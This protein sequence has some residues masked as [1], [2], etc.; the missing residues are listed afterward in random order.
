MIVVKNDSLPDYNERVIQSPVLRFLA[1]LL[2]Y[3]FHPA[4]VPV[5]MILFMVYQHPYFF[6][7]MMPQDKFRVTA[8]SVLMFSFFPIVTVGLLKALGFI[9]SIYLHTQ[10]DRIIPLVACGVFY[11][12]ITY[13]W[14]NSNKINGNFFIP[15]EAVQFA[16]ATFF[17]SWLALMI[18]IKIKI[19]LHA[20][21]MG[22]LLTA[23]L[24]FALAG[25]INFGLWLSIALL[26]TG[27]VCTSRLIISDHKQIEIYLGILA[28]AVAVLGADLFIRYFS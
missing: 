2:S 19:S 3:I 12:W 11:F 28:G 8:M 20:I 16:L 21:S 22:V 15:R 24:Q 5:Y 18:N 26:C 25:Q 4:F 6:A 10:K 9:Q 23:M 27:L 13:I 7:G 14:W 1:K 17:A